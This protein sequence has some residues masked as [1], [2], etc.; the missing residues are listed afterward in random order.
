MNVR[1]TTREIADEVREQEITF[2][3]AGIAF[4]AF[5]SILPALLL[6]LALVS[7]VGGESIA[8]EVVTTAQRFLSP[9]AEAVIY[10]AFTT[11]SGRGS[12]TIV[13]ILVLVWSTLRVFRGLDKAFSR[14]YDSNHEESFVE[15]LVDAS[16]VV[17]VI[18]L[19]LLGLG[20][21]RIVFSAFSWVPFA[22]TVSSIVVLLALVPVLLPLYYFFPDADVTVRQ[23]LPGT[24]LATVG[25]VVLQ[26]LFQAYAESAAQFAAYG[27]L[28]GALLLVSWLYLGAIVLLLGAVVNAVLAGGTFRKTKD[29]GA[30]NSKQQVDSGEYMTDDTEQSAPDILKLHGDVERLQSE[31]E[32]FEQD[33]DE[34]TVQ[35]PELESELKRYVRRRMRRGHARGWGPYLVLLYGTVMTLGAFRWL[36]SGWAIAAM[37]VIWLST[38]GLYTLMV[39]VGF[40][41]SAVGVPGRV[42][43]RIR[44]WRS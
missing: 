20:L 30:T 24:I 7:I 35:K 27:V 6:G 37:L 8:T 32:E 14:V 31:F 26:A 11:R 43:G 12:A 3:A 38:L 25:W 29:A 21:G 17:V 33:V 34:R 5:V 39:L 42:G 1:V 28:G 16:I 18:A 22:K 36:E 15:T 9:A 19:A 41:V 13:G 2:L 10:E 23:A 40:G 44:D 4:Y